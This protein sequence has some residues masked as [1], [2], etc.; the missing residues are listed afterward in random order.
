MSAESARWPRC[1]RGWRGQRYLIC[2][3]RASSE[4]MSTLVVNSQ[5]FVFQSFVQI[6]ESVL[7]PIP[8][9]P[10]LGAMSRHRNLSVCIAALLRDND[11]TGLGEHQI[12]S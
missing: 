6:G 10:P 7:P 3:I 1:R 12:R 4:R 2:S 8:Q 11:E 5:P 9:V